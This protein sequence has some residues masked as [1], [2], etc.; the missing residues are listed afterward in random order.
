MQS[1]KDYLCEAA[2]QG[3]QYENNAAEAL[4]PYDVVPKSFIPGL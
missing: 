3:F 4:K 2:Q 1:F